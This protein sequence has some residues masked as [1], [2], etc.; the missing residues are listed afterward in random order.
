MN[1]DKF[2]N[3]LSTFPLSPRFQRWIHKLSYQRIIQTKKLSM[4][5]DQEETRNKKQETRNKKQE[6]KVKEQYEE[7]RRRQLRSEGLLCSIEN[8]FKSMVIS[9]EPFP[10]DLVG[11]YINMNWENIDTIF[12]LDLLII[13]K[14]DFERMCKN[15]WTKKFLASKSFWDNCIK[16]IGY[17]KCWQDMEKRKSLQKFP[18]DNLRKT[19][20]SLKWKRT[21]FFRLLRFEIAFARLNKYQ[22]VRWLLKVEGGDWFKEEEKTNRHFFIVYLLLGTWNRAAFPLCR[23]VLLDLFNLLEALFLSLRFLLAALLIEQ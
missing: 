1:I 10:I 18:L 12:S 4:W 13:P 23:P 2:V 19:R 21:E 22:V 5:P 6:N 20:V 9:Q 17:R 14:G 11:W 3:E 15:P 7:E 8:L 16:I